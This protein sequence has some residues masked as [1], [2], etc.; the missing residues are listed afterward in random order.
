M[1]TNPYEPTDGADEDI[2]WLGQR[3][4]EFRAKDLALFRRMVREAL[5]RG[6]AELDAR[7]YAY[8]RLLGAQ[9][10]APSRVWAR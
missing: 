4:G 7:N 5:E 2:L 9:L 3:K 10:W 8:G 1:T 6:W